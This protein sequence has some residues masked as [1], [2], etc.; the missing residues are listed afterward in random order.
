MAWGKR[1]TLPG[2]FGGMGQEG[3]FT[4]LVW[5]HGVRGSLYQ[6]CLVAWGKRATLPGLFGGMG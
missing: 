1:V 6:A 3:H 5:W 4:R 2:L